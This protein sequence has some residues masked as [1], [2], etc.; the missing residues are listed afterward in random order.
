MKFSLTNIKN[1][2]KRFRLRSF[3]SKQAK[4]FNS[5]EYWEDRYR[6]RG[7][8]GPG[9][10]GRLAEWKALILNN[11]VQE[12]QVDLVLELGCGDG[13]Q[14][15]LADYTKYIGFDVSTKA[16]EICTQIFRLDSSKT[17]L[18][19]KKIEG[20]SDRSA[21]LV[22]SL[23]VVFHL[24]EDDVYQE[25]LYNLFRLSEKYVIIYSSNYN[26]RLARHVRCRRFTDW[27]D[28]NV[29]GTFELQ[30]IIENKYPFQ[31]NLP[32]TSSISD[33]YIYRRKM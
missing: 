4:P 10:Y 7:N 8:S 19:Y 22:I 23:D 31:E 33:F 2:L 32:D 13:N 24:I 6:S 12:K 20:F 3:L 18:E 21:E 16:V 15:Q 26:A 28:Q 27:V 14:L 25:Y 9:S 5:K 1:A 17:F 29:A 30:Q 11:F